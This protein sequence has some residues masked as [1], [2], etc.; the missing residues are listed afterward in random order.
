MPCRGAAHT[1]D[2]GQCYLDKACE[3]DASGR[4]WAAERE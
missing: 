2:C 4:R 1:S 3:C